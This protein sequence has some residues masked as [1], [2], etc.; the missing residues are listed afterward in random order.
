M[1]LSNGDWRQQKVTALEDKAVVGKLQR[2]LRR[3]FSM[4]N[5]QNK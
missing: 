1:T 4:T 2:W 5:S 3:S